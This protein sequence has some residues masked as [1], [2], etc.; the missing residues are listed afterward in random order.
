MI[1]RQ[2]LG[3]KIL[4]NITSYGENKKEIIE[5]KSVTIWKEKEY[6]QIKVNNNVTLIG[7]S[8]FYHNQSSP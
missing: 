5:F 3:G 2:N 1:Y 4:N 8:N 6:E 7:I